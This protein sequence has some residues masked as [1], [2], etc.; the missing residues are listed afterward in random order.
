MADSNSTYLTITANAG[1][2]KTVTVGGREFLEV[3]VTMIVSGVLPGSK[4]PLYYPPQQIAANVGAWDGKPVTLYHPHVGGVPARADHPSVKHQHIGRITRTRFD[5]TRNRLQ[6]HAL[7][8]VALANAVEKGRYVLTELRAGRQVELSTGLFTANVDA[9]AGSVDGKG[10]PYT[11]VAT[12][13]R[14]DH[15]AILPDQVGACSIKDGCGVLVNSSSSPQENPVPE[16]ER[17]SVWNALGKALGFLKNE[18]GIAANEGQPR[19]PKAGI[20]QPHGFKGMGKGDSHGAAKVG[21]TDDRKRHEDTTPESNGYDEDE[22]EETLEAKPMP[23]TRNEKLE[24]LTANCSC[25]GEKVALNALGDTWLDL[26]IRN[27]K[28]PGSHADVSGGGTKQVGGEEEDPDAHDPAAVMKKGR[29]PFQSASKNASLSGTV[30]GTGAVAAG[31]DGGSHSSDAI[32]PSGS[33]SKN[34]SAGGG[35]SAFASAAPVVVD[36]APSDSTAKNAVANGRGGAVSVK[37]GFAA[38]LREHGTA[39]EIEVW[40]SAVRVNTETRGRI[41]GRLTANAKVEDKPG[42]V[43][44]YNAMTLE[45][46]EAVARSFAPVSNQGYGGRTVLDVGATAVRPTLFVAD[47]GLTANSKLQGR[48][49]SL[50]LPV[51]NYKEIAEENRAARTG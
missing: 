27:A 30:G 35:G 15:L 22:P 14:P 29:M 37:K 26:L 4:G 28:L 17:F 21:L 2:A 43:A 36:Y 20:F 42:L 13:Y 8:D 11:H 47:A 1:T 5:P 9:P 34:A 18:D 40:N 33:A 48:K 7:I 39:E 6:A 10:R 44:V 31:V 46:L 12:N 51:M 16:E 41:V 45:Q 19:C 23:I 24:F 3:P 50:P 32:S 38:L 49:A 25:E